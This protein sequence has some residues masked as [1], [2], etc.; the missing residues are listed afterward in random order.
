MMSQRLDIENANYIYTNTK[1]A[2]IAEHN[3]V[4][5]SSNSDSMGSY[6]SPKADWRLLIKCNIY[7]IP[8]LGTLLGR[9]EHR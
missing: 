8:I 1:E 4:S 5:K 3:L 9:L 6:D 7:M 2:I